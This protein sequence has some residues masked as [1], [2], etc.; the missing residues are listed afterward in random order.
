[1]FETEIAFGQGSGTREG[2]TVTLSE[3][4]IR[5]DGLGT[6]ITLRRITKKVLSTNKTKK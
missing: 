3:P 1:M 2:F 6:R 5:G 4:I